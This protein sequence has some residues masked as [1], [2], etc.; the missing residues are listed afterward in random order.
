MN[1]PVQNTEPTP[2]NVPQ[3]EISND[4]E[5]TPLDASQGKSVTTGSGSLESALAATASTAITAVQSELD[6]V[7]TSPVGSINNPGAETSNTPPSD[8]IADAKPTASDSSQVEKATSVPQELGPAPITPDVV[9]KVL[10]VKDSSEN[11]DSNLGAPDLE[12]DS[13]RRPSNTHR[14]HIL[15]DAE[16]T[17]SDS[18]Q[19]SR[20][21]DASVEHGPAAV[22][23]AGKATTVLSGGESSGIL[24]PNLG[25]L[26][27]GSDSFYSF[28]AEFTGRTSP[29]E[30]PVVSRADSAKSLPEGSVLG[31][32]AGPSNTHL[33]DI[34][35]GAEPTPSDSSQA[36]RATDTSVER[37]PAAITPAVVSA[38]L[39][40]EESSGI[41]ACNLGALDLGYRDFGS[42]DFDHSFQSLFTSFSGLGSSEEAHVRPQEHSGQ[43]SLGGFVHNA[44]RDTSGPS[45]SDFIDNAELT[46]FGA[47]EGENVTDTTPDPG[48]TRITPTMRTTGAFRPPAGVR[49]AVAAGTAPTVKPTSSSS[50]G[51]SVPGPG[52]HRPKTP[53][54]DIVGN[55][56]PVS[57]DGSHVLGPIVSEQPKYHQI[58]QFTPGELVDWLDKN[59]FFTQFGPRRGPEIYQIFLSSDLTGQTLLRKGHSLAWCRQFFSPGV[60]DALSDLV[61]STYAHSG[62]YSIPDK[63]NRIA[64]NDILLILT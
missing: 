49:T 10:G 35:G 14:S 31:A 50:P 45:K 48:L 3:L 4:V 26:E 63:K 28:V 40:V 9:T 34:V 42:D 39:G 16:P 5:Q 64:P 52:A 33:S 12:S 29:G 59:S 43:R 13:F 8:I 19:A 62:M 11:L 51:G 44:G 60:S 1:N 23:S 61:R 22:T 24:A 57:A 21:T 32:E 53:P 27:L 25:P 18:L 30:L 55:T 6:L 54:S 17:L 46:P 38:D 47:S 37:R 2:P 56:K 20:V 36:G 41:S 7:E 15:R 58:I